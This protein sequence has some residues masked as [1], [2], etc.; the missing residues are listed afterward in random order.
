LEGLLRAGAGP[1][2]NLV[3][4]EL[5]KL[6]SGGPL[7][8]PDLG[9]TIEEERQALLTFLGVATLPLGAAVG[10]PGAVAA[11]ERGAVRGMMF[12]TDPRGGFFKGLGVGLGN[13][14]LLEG[15]GPIREI[16]GNKPFNF[17]LAVGNTLGAP[18]N[19][20]LRAS[21]VGF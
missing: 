5:E 21:G 13:Q 14:L 6:R 9:P 10:G 2:Q 12:L 20:I 17:G 19:A 8:G 1:R 7:A 11:A 3:A 4:A 18:L 16:P 15:E